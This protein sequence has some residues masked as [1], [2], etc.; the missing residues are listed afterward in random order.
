MEVRKKSRLGAY[1][2]PGVT[3]I[4][5]VVDF[6]RFYQWTE[7]TLFGFTD[8][9]CAVKGNAFLAEIAKVARVDGYIKL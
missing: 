3:S 1:R 9:D 8:C 7:P 5:I 2:V 4:I 6:V